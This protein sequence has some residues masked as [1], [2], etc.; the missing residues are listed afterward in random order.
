MAPHIFINLYHIQYIYCISVYLQSCKN[1]RTYV[2]QSI[3]MWP[4]AADLPGPQ[5][6]WHPNRGGLG[7][8]HARRG[9][10]A[11]SGR[12][13]GRRDATGTEAG[14]VH[15]SYPAAAEYVPT[16]KGGVDWDW[17]IWLGDWEIWFVCFFDVVLSHDVW[18]LLFERRLGSDR[19]T[20]MYKGTHSKGRAIYRFCL[21][22]L[23]MWVVPC[24]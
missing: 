19:L 13:R 1:Y 15:E 11:G 2:S 4:L 6:L 9:G 5:W 3:W 18:I 22:H 12:R 20:K 14:N 7:G 10:H 8:A 21:D 16:N 23:S 17:W 24:T